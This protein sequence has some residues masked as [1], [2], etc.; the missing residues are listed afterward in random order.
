MQWFEKLANWIERRGGKRELFRQGADG[1]PSLYMERY[2]LVKSKYFELM[3]HRFHMSDAIDVHD[4]S[5][6]I[7]WGYSQKWLL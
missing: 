6:G 4:Q 7:I 1:E 5:L 2:Y 3:I